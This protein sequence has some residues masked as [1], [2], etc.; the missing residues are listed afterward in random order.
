MSII[1]AS[2]CGLIQDHFFA[3][4]PAPTRI[5]LSLRDHLSVSQWPLLHSERNTKPP[6]VRSR[7]ADKSSRGIFKCAKIARFTTKGGNTETLKT[8]MASL[9]AAMAVAQPVTVKGLSGSSLHGTKLSIRPSR[10]VAARSTSRYLIHFM[11][12]FS[13]TDQ[14]TCSLELV[15]ALFC[16]RSSGAVVAKYGDKSVYFDLE[17]LGN[18]TGQWDLYGSDAPS[19]YNPLQVFVCACV[20]VYIY[21]FDFL[22]FINE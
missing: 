10:R 1:R 8:Q 7:F 13:I 6:H 11:L 17:D 21:I 20:C 12:A 22:C 2:F 19:P 5:R 18:T 16:L 4:A 9:T 3:F 15:V 14:I